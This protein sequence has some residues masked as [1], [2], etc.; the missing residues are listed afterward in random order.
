MVTIAHRLD[1]VIGSDRILV[2][3]NGRVKEFDHPHALLMKEEGYFSK[4]VKA[5]GKWRAEKLHKAALTAFE[6]K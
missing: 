1:T 3:S 2:L 6:V 4:M 5:S